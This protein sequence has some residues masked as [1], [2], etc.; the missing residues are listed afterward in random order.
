MISKPEDVYKDTTDLIAR[1]RLQSS[2]VEAYRD[3]VSGAVRRLVRDPDNRVEAEQVAMLGLLVALERYD[4]AAAHP[5]GPREDRG[6]AFWH[7]AFPFVRNEVQRWMDHGVFWRP[8][9][10]NAHGQGTAELARL[11]RTPAS[12]DAGDVDETLHDQIKSTVA[13]VEDQVADGELKLRLRAFVRTLSAEDAKILLTENGQCRQ[14]GRY[15][16]LV[17]RAAAFVRGSDVE[18]QTTVETRDN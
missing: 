5:E 12:M 16:S 3:R 14:S 13:S 11:H 4:R 17:G 6:G 7:F 8:R 9:K 18:Y 2:V 15:Q 1:R 10:R